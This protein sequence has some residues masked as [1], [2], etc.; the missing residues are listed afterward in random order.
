MRKWQYKIVPLK[1]IFENSSDH[2][3][4]VSIE[5][6]KTKSE[7][8]RS[9]M[10]KKLNELGNEGWELTCAFGEFVLLKKEE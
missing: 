2:N 10:E 4:D 6:G 3:I 1:S 9:G 7:K 5:E 8:T